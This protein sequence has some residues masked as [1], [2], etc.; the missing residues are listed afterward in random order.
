MNASP[1]NYSGR[2]P[3]GIGGRLFVSLFFLVFLSAGLMFVWLIARDAW[4]GLRNWSWSAT[5]CEITRSEVR[6]NDKRARNGGDFLVDLE[7]RYRFGGNTFL[8]NRLK[9]G[10]NTFADYT[11]AER[12]AE[13]FPPG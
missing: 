7:Y 10:A 3:L 2:S 6:Q 9:V 4:K 12:L 11:A 8:S 1:Q 13:S 5:D